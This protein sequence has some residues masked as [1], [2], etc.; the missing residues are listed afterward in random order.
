[1]I[2]FPGLNFF[3]Y[4]DLNL[5]SDVITG[6]EELYLFDENVNEADSQVEIFYILSQDPPDE[7]LPIGGALHIATL[8][9][10]L[11]ETSN[12]F[13]V[14]MD[15]MNMT[16]EAGISLTD[17]SIGDTLWISDISRQIVDI[18]ATEIITDS[19]FDILLLSGT[20]VYILSKT[21]IFLNYD[22]NDTNLGIRW[23]IMDF[24]LESGDYGLPQSLSQIITT[25]NELY[26]YSTFYDVIL[27]IDTN[28]TPNLGNS[29][30][31]FE[32]IPVTAYF[33]GGNVTITWGSHLRTIGN[34][35]INYHPSE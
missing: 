33:A 10:N 2:V 15:D 8:N 1:L 21:H 27:I 24:Y 35:N 25:Q 12:R 17:Y 19:G 34:L 22:Y 28:F 5:D 31:N 23:D 13:L 11:S 26:E 16:L 9:K 4:I 18:S 30:S 14:D 3:T 20:R 6:G 32:F 7:Y 29:F